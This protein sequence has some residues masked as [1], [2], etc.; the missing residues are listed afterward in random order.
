MV[1]HRLVACNGSPIRKCS[2]VIVTLGLAA[3]STTAPAQAFA[4][5]SCAPAAWPTLAPR[6]TRPANCSVSS[7]TS[8]SST[9]RALRRGSSASYSAGR[10][11]GRDVVG[12]TVVEKVLPKRLPCV[13][14]PG[15][16]RQA[17]ALRKLANFAT[18]NRGLKGG[19]PA[20]LS[21]RSST[22]TSSSR[23]RDRE[24]RVVVAAAAHVDKGEM[25]M[26][27]GR[28]APYGR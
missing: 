8:R 1:G 20:C 14:V 6:W 17:V 25:A 23:M 9:S 22:T 21:I 26:P 13:G 10:R 27:R 7:A 12:D 18:A 4:Q 16:G 11:Q 28:Q 15:D 19:L 24:H 5:S 3:A 2:A